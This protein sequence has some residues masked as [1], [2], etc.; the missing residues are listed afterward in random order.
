MKFR[1]VRCLAAVALLVGLA[2]SAAALEVSLGD[3]V[4]VLKTYEGVKPASFPHR[5]H[6][7][8]LSCTSCHHVRENVMVIDRCISCHNE[9]MPNAELNS[10]K[11]AGHGLCVTCHKKV[12]AEGGAAPRRCSSCHP[13][14][15]KKH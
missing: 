9:T 13:L 11:A 7:Q 10:L 12:T 1:V 2:T 8:F 6:Q 5:D 4:I 3:E 14:E 15:I